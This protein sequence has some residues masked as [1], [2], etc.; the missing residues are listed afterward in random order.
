MKLMNAV[1]AGVSGTVTEILAND[2][3]LVE[4]GETLLRVRKD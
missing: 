2:G 1:R 3:V 4:F